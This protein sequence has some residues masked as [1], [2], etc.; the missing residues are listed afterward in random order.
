MQCPRCPQGPEMVRRT[1]RR[2]AQFLV[3]AVLLLGVG[4]TLQFLAVA[5]W[6]WIFYGIGAF[7]LS[8]GALKWVDCRNAYCP[9]CMFRMYVWPWSK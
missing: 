2:P 8:Q 7:V 1:D 9:G 4:A 6:P 3:F 5:L